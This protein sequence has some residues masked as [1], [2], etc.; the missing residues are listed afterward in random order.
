VQDAAQVGTVGPECPAC[1]TTAGP[2]PGRGFPQ[3]G[4]NTL[5]P[6]AQPDLLDNYELGS[7]GNLFGGRARFD[8]AVYYMNWKRVQESITVEVDGVPYSATVNGK[9]ASGTG[10]DLALTT[11][12]IDK[13]TLAGSFSW[14]SLRMDTDVYSGGALLFPEGS[15]LNLS[16]EYTA[17]VTADYEFPFLATG[18]DAHV[19]ASGNYVSNMVNRVLLGSAADV[20]RGDPEFIARASF[21]LSSP[22]GW[23]GRLYGD[24]LGNYQKSPV[25]GYGNLAEYYG[26]VRPRTVGL[27]LEY[28]TDTSTGMNWDYIIVGAGSAGCALAWQLARKAG[29]PKILVI[30]AGGSDRSPYIKVPLGQIRA[31][32]RYDW[33]YRSQPDPSRGGAS[34]AWLR[35][36][37]LGGS[38]SGRDDYEDVAVRFLP[39]LDPLARTVKLIFSGTGE[40]I[41]LDLRL[42]PAARP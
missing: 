2:V 21:S 38:S 41:A 33:G 14:N 12:V 7:K 37:V 23:T 36:K 10:V 27:Q 19:S 22:S 13:L 20:G 28:S 16:P 32:T 1:V 35:G 11:E 31:I 39:R 18:L 25:P 4:P 9:S 8:V 3:A 15:R 26:R 6:A 5:L 29:E 40:Q 34:D 30:E 17:G 24:N 42:E